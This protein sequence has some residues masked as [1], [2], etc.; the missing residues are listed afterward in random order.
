VQFLAAYIMKGRLQAMTVAATMALLSLP[1]PPVSIVSSASVA[2]VTLRRGAGE[3]LYV[4]LCACLAAAA[5]SVVLSIGYQFALLY[6]FV[7]WIPIWLISIVL[8]EGKYLAVAIEI[9]VLLGI[10]A[11]LA[12]YWYE[13]QPAQFWNPVLAVMIQP[14][15]EAGSDVPVEQIKQMAQAFAHFMTGAV[16]AGS[17]FSLLFGLFL[18]RWW[19]AALYNPGGFRAE[20]LALKG[21]PQLAMI[22]IAILAAAWLLSGVVSELCWNVV[23]VLFVLYTFIGTAVL[24]ASFSVMKRGRFM[25]PFLYVTLLLIPHVMGIIAICGLMDH[26]LD[27]RKKI[28]NQTAD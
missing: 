15:L 4:L 10:V 17:V 19:Q 18:A 8:R 14:M 5:L 2:L 22:S 6:G 21:H 7:L 23:V 28:S 11:V 3:G 1:F 24:H 27:L 12:F 26:W 9:A 20:F 13:P 25:V 16:A